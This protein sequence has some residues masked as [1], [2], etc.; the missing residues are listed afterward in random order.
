MVTVGS[1]IGGTFR[2]VMANLRSIAVWAGI[3]LLLGI[4]MRLGM[5]PFYQAQAAAITARAQGLPPTTPPFGSFFLV[6]LAMML[7]LLVLYNAVFRAVLFP[8]DRGF[9]Y[10]RVGMDELRLLGLMVVL[11]VAYFLFSFL[12]GLVIGVL[13]AILT[14]SMGAGRGAMPVI[15][16]LLALVV[17]IPFIFVAIRLSVVGP[18][19]LWRREIVIGPAWRLTKGRFW[20]LFGAYFVVWLV[21]LIAMLVVMLPMMAPMFAAMGT[22]MSQPGNPEAAQRMAEAQM[23]MMQLSLTPFGILWLIVSSLF[24]GVLVAIFG[25]LPAVATAQLLDEQ[26][27]RL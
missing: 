5:A 19:T 18:L 15:F 2:F 27:G 7:I 4:V 13:G 23:A 1:I 9:A 14:L 6:M 22:A 3:N 24:G 8:E 20:T 12:L 21:L 26:A 17:F 11:T 25:G 10:L 16:L